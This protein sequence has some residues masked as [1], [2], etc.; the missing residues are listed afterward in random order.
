MRASAPTCKALAAL[1]CRIFDTTYNPGAVRTGA[2]Y[3]RQRLVGPA[4][5]S[6]YRPQLNLRSAIASVGGLPGWSKEDGP[7]LAPHEVQR[8][9]DVARRK[10]MGKG[11]PKKGEGRRAAMKGKKGR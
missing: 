11:P 7:L 5:L 6:Y 2:K 9:T 3:L 8:L 1:R 10:E 4:M